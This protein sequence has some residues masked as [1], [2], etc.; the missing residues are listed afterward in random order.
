MKELPGPKKLHVPMCVGGAG[1]LHLDESDEAAGPRLTV[2]G[3]AGE[4]G[5][6]ACPSTWKSTA[7]AVGRRDVCRE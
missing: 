5:G 3:L 6:R 1:P 7:R 2:R 4:G